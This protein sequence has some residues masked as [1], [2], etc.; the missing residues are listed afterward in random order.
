MVAECRSEVR[1]L[2]THHVPLW[3]QITGGLQQGPRAV[4]DHVAPPSA[5]CA[6]YAGFD[7]GPPRRCSPVTMP[8]HRAL[9]APCGGSKAPPCRWRNMIGSRSSA[10]SYKLLLLRLECAAEV[11]HSPLHHQK[12][13]DL[14]RTAEQRCAAQITTYSTNWWSTV[15]WLDP[16]P[17]I[18][19]DA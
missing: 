4:S 10:S 2:L 18:R 9:L 7:F 5:L 15:A 8:K 1:P 14:C 11:P 12:V 19:S 13:A 3:V 16:I 17:G 6:R